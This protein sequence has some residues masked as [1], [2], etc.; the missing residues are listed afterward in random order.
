MVT[1]C[2]KLQARHYCPVKPSSAIGTWIHS[3]GPHHP[4]SW[5]V[6]QQTRTSQSTL[7]THMAVD[8]WRRSQQHHPV[9]PIR[10]RLVMDLRAERSPGFP[11]RREI[12]FRMTDVT[13]HKHRDAPRRSVVRE[14]RRVGPR[15][16]RGPGPGR[17]AARTRYD[18][19][20]DRVT[21]SRAARFGRVAG[22]G[23]RPRQGFS[24]MP[25]ATCQ[26][27]TPLMPMFRILPAFSSPV[28]AKDAR[29]H[30]CPHS[31]ASCGVDRPPQ[32]RVS[33]SA[34]QHTACR[35]GVAP[36]TSAGSTLRCVVAV[37]VAV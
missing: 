36:P 9:Q 26:E 23:V 25:S 30:T 7:S 21:A 32:L 18:R 14:S 29:S 5:K 10:C 34:C 22:T 20:R 3:R 2:V 4:A 6:F 11:T 17:R 16:C 31:A 24:D 13:D 19:A 12:P 1:A 15:H 27:I 35:S 28:P 8:S 33:F 37:T